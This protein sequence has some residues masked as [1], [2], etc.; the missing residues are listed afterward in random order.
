MTRP[1]NDRQPWTWFW[2][3]IWFLFCAIGTNYLIA[4]FY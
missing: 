3:L 2:L 1:L 4:L